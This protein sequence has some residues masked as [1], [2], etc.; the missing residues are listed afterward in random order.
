MITQ[1]GHDAVIPWYH[2]GQK[3]VSANDLMDKLPVGTCLSV[4]LRD[5]DNNGV[6]CMQVTPAGELSAHTC[7]IRYQWAHHTRSSILTCLDLLQHFC[8][9][10]LSV[11]Q[12][13]LLLMM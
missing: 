5:M 3:V 12:A 10:L 2:V 7:D 9:Y 1:Q 8:L 6:P 4:K 11:A 13:L